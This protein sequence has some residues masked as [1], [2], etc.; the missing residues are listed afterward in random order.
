MI[1]MPSYEMVRRR[2]AAQA[3]RDHFDGKIHNWGTVDC[4]RMIAWHLR[5]FSHRPRLN[6]FG[7]YRTARGAFAALKR[8]GFASMGAVLDDLGLQRIAPAD[9]KL[10]DIV[11]GESSDPFDAL[12][13]YIGNEALF[14]F[15]EDVPHATTLRRIMPAAAW[16]VI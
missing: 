1:M 14:G 6:R 8:A 9:A 13:I 10:A 3:T 4:G 2:D 5:Q 12:A 15:H 16:S 11:S 7:S